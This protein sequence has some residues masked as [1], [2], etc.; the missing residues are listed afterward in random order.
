MLWPVHSLLATIAASMLLTVVLGLFCLHLYRRDDRPYLGVWALAVF[1]FAVRHMFVALGVLYPRLAALGQFGDALTSI[2]AVLLFC[3]A[4][5]AFLRQTP[6]RAWFYIALLYLMASVALFIVYPS[7][8]AVLMPAVFA[9]VVAVRTALLYLHSPGLDSATRRAPAIGL[10][11]FTAQI[12]LIPFA[13]NTIRAAVGSLFGSSLLYACVGLG[14]L[15]A[16]YEKAKAALR[17]SESRFRG[18]FEASLEGILI[19]TEDGNVIE[20]NPAAATLFGHAPGELVGR[21]I[22]DLVDI[23]ESSWPNAIPRDALLRLETDCA[24]KDGSTFAAEVVARR[25]LYRDHPAVVVAVRDVTERKK[26][27]ESIRQSERRLRDMLE[28]VHLISAMLDGRGRITFC[29]DFLLQLSGWSREAV[30]GQDWFDVFVPPEDREA[31]RRRFASNLVSGRSSSHMTTE[32][33][34]KDGSRRMI[35][36]NITVLTDEV[37]RAVGTASIGEDITDRMRAQATLAAERERLAVTLRSIAD[38]VIAT[39]AEGRITLLNKVAEDLTGWTEKEARGR[40]ITDVL[41]F[42]QGEGSQTHPVHRVLAEGKALDFR[43]DTILVTRSD[44]ELMVEHSVSPIRDAQGVTMGAVLV[45]RD[46]TEKQRLER[47]LQRASKLEAIGLLA[48][49]IAHDFNNL[50][51]AIGGNISLA[52]LSLEA[53][54]EAKESLAEAEK[55]TYRARDLTQQLLTFAKGGAPIKETASL[56][57]L[58]RDSTGFALRG[59]PVRCHFDIAEDL[60]PVEVDRGQISQVVNN[61]V[62]NAVEAMPTGGFIKVSAENVRVDGD[63]VALP[64]GDYV[65]VVV[66]DHGV[67]I[68]PDRMDR[69]FDPYYST[70]EGGSGLGLATTYSI[71]RRHNGHI[72]VESQIG[73]GSTFRVYLPALPNAVR[74]QRP[75]PAPPP[76]LQGRRGRILVMDDEETVRRVVKK[77]LERLGYEVAVVAEGEAAIQAYLEARG[78]GEQYDAVIMDLTVPGGMG[79]KEAA[80]ALRS[81]DPKACIIASSGYSNDPVMSESAAYGFS[82]VIAKPYRP[83]ELDELLRRVMADAAAHAA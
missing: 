46:V 16:Y 4:S 66:Q 9:A 50:L 28:S 59:L 74:Q 3:W 82:G 55:A 34:L 67:G 19:V 12:L 43:N 48:G 8:A 73:V 52:S 23:P 38:G 63:E 27:D 51:T 6:P 44:K 71:V 20:A 57:E 70:K 64:P 49:G 47:E 13:G 58:L 80:R 62:M 72:E 21:R 32:L 11:V 42:P 22:S 14:I 75:E 69:I 2:G 45:F 83:T 40:M 36:W 24:R 29:N 5:Y 26:A 1:A 76:V 31:H 35:S 61:L 77:T 33:L 79:G 10:A 39:D 60:W 17:D 37:G 54:E 41:D 81:V 7:P 25:Q 53:D 15:T 56:V 18:L 65:R 68:P 30:I 78:S